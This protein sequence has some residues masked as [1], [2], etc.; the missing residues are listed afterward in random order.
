MQAT[1][2][3][4]DNS[5]FRNC[6]FYFRKDVWDAVSK[7]ALERLISVHFSPIDQVR[8]ILDP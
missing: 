2:Y 4:T 3:I 8:Q 1:F 6:T 5:K 7:P